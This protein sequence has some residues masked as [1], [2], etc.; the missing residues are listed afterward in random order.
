MTAISSYVPVASSGVAPDDSVSS[1]DRASHLASF[2]INGRFYGQVVTGV[3]RYAREITR[4]VDLILARDNRRCRMLVPAGVQPHEVFTS[5]DVEPSGPLSGHLWEQVVLPMRAGAPILNLGNTGPALAAS[6]VVCLHDANVFVRP[7]SYSTSFRL[8][9]RVLLPLLARRAA[10]VTSVSQAAARQLA[11]VLPI[12]AR[13]IAIL[14]NGHEHVFRWNPAAS[15]LATAF[16]HRRPFVLLI[17]SRARHKN[18]ALILNQADNLDRLGLDLVVAGGGAGIFSTTE[19]VSGSNVRSLGSVTDDDLAFLYQNALCL[20]FPS[21]TEGFGLPI[22]EA[23]ALGC[24]VV[25]SDRA[26]MPEV[27]GDA[28]LLAAPDD[29]RAFLDHIAALAHSAALR[30]DLQGRGRE[31]VKQFSWTRSADG[32]LNLIGRLQ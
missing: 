24:P 28:A 16:E 18:A 19:A 1:R 5:I 20:V 4:Q 15:K 12:S 6:Q 14:P 11:S 8:A 23:M 32:Y 25:S 3:Q 9:Y 29:G 26:C 30:D 2:V 21:W 22:V 17:G 10:H 31:Q 7:D 13:D 27:C